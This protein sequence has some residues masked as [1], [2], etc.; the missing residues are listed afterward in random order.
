VVWIAYRSADSLVALLGQARAR[1]VTRITAFLLLCIGT[2]IL[3]N[4]AIDVLTPLLAGH[5]G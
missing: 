2:Q 5:R 1:V 3:L 4:G